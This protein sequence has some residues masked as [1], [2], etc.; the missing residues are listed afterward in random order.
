MKMQIAL[1]A[2]GLTLA[3]VSVAQADIL[4]DNGPID[5]QDIAFT[6][7][8]GFAVS[9]SFTLTSSSTLTGV[10]FGSWSIPGD[11]IIGVDWAITTAP[12][13]YP[14]DGTAAVT[15][16]GVFTNS[17]GYDVGTASFS[18]PNVTLAAGT[19]YLV[20]QNAT[21]PLGDPTYW[22][23]NNGPSSAYDSGIGSLQ[24]YFFTGTNSESFQIIGTAAG[25]T[26]G[27]PE[28][29]SWAMMITGF[30]LVGGALRASR[31]TIAFAV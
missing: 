17:L 10:N 1:V 7:N 5:G 28:P 6:I 23:D 27:V 4:Y 3:G 21:T 31:R 11:D 19:Y 8:S 15:L 30:G 14:V 9:N 12:D 13:S 24:D 25:G 16:S 18:L 2:A 26:G 20:L 29:A 22:D